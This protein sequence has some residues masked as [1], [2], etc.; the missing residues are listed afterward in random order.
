MSRSCEGFD[1]ARSKQRRRT[2]TSHSADAWGVFE[3]GFQLVDEGLLVCIVVK[4]GQ[5]QFIVQFCTYTPPPLDSYLVG[6]TQSELSTLTETSANAID[7][8]DMQTPNILIIRY[9]K[10]PSDRPIV[11][12]NPSSQ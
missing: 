5:D 1:L 6:Y 10:S 12:V 9:E 3:E 11:P 2:E 8:L 4:V 7:T